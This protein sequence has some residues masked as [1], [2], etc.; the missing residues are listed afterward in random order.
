MGMIKSR[1]V[2]WYTNY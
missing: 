1:C 2:S